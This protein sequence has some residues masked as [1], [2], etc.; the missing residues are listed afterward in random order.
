[1]KTLSTQELTALLRSQLKA[2]KAIDHS[3]MSTMPIGQFRERLPE[4]QI[5][6]LQ[7]DRDHQRYGCRAT[8]YIQFGKPITHLEMHN[9]RISIG[10]YTDYM[11]VDVR[12]GSNGYIAATLEMHGTVICNSSDLFEALMA[13]AIRTHRGTRVLAE[14]REKIEWS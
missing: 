4:L 11:R 14:Y 6:C 9:N 1:M 3:N 2:R 8:P 10:I 12:S 5:R 7:M 13:E